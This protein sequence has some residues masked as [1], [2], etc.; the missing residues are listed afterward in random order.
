MIKNETFNF[1]ILGINDFTYTRGRFS[2]IVK[3][4]N[5]NFNDEAILYVKG[6]EKSMG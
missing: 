2:L 1:E 4:P 6:D 3:R 5:T